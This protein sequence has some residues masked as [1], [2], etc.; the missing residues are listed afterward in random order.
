M[1]DRH[2]AIAGAGPGGL[3]G[4]CYLVVFGTHPGP[5]LPTIYESGRISAKMIS[6]EIR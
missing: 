2:I 3:T 4:N 5:G 6:R 1:A